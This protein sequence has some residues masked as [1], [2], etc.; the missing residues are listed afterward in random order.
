MHLHVASCEFHLPSMRTLKNEY[1]RGMLAAVLMR[2]S[3]TKQHEM[4]MSDFES[5]RPRSCLGVFTSPSSRLFVVKTITFL[6]SL[7]T[8]TSTAGPAP[9]SPGYQGLGHLGAASVGGAAR[10]RRCRWLLPV[11]QWARPARLAHHQQ[12][13]C[14]R[15]QVRG[16]QRHPG[17]VREKAELIWKLYRW[18]RTD[19]KPSFVQIHCPW[20]GDWKGVR[21][22]RQV[23]QPSRKQRLLWRIR[24]HSCQGCHSWVLLSTMFCCT[25]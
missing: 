15:L 11:L 4:R 25:T 20:T 2:C 7:L 5:V 3:G 18:P 8:Q 13:A 6:L 9:L 22:S 16:G 24:A 14:H 10:Q 12:Q 1:T 23:S 19:W 17:G 21:L